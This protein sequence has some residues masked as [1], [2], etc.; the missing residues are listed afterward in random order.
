MSVNAEGI[1][2]I[3]AIKK[4]RNLMDLLNMI[5]PENKQVEQFEQ[6]VGKEL[7]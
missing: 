6:P 2:Q 5:T 7:I 3:K 4:E 1:I